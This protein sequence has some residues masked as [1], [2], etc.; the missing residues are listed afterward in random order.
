MYYPLLSSLF[1]IDYLFRSGM[2]IPWFINKC[3]FFEKQLPA[4]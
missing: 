2:M 4:L 1:F 3:R